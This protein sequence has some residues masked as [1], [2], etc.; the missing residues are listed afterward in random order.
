MLDR[1]REVIGKS[2]WKVGVSYGDELTLDIGDKLPY[3]QKVMKGKLKGEYVL[4]VRDSYWA[5]T[6]GT[7]HIT[8]DNEGVDSFLNKVKVT[9][10]TLITDIQTDGRFSVLTVTFDNSYTL[11][12]YPTM[13]EQG[14]D[15]WE[16]F[17][18][19][20]EFIHMRPGRILSLDRSDVPM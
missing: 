1:L 4:G 7:K 3:K 8:D 16:L 15:Y 9:E 13:E 19:G 2:C 12:V 11:D 10:N 20:N 6:L 18:P 14:L 5:L 17:L